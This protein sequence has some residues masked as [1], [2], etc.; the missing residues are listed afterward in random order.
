MSRVDDS[1]GARVG[2][3]RRRRGLTQEQLAERAEVDVS[4]VRKLEQGARDGARLSTLHNLARALDVRT[5]DLF[6]GGGAPAPITADAGTVDLI[7]LREVLTPVGEPEVSQGEEAPDLGR[8]RRSYEAIYARYERNEYEATAQAVP[9][10]ITHARQ[11]LANADGTQRGEA[12]QLLCYALHMAGSLLTQLRRFDLAYFPLREA[13]GLARDGGHLL[14]EA[15]ISTGLAW[16][17]MEQ[18]RLGDTAQVAVDTA[19]RVEPRMSHATPEEI[20]AWGRLLLFASGAAIRNN[21]PHEAADILRLTDTAAANLGDRRPR[22]SIGPF[23]RTIVARRQVENAVIAGD[24]RR[25]LNVAEGIVNTDAPSSVNRNRYLLDVAHAHTAQRDYTEAVDVLRVI[26]HHAPEWLRHQ[27]YARDIMARLLH[28]R[29][30]P[31]TDEMRELADL[32][33]VD[34]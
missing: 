21:E 24:T 16:L 31:V 26:Q 8:L 32:L 20:N 5:S 19:D 22:W 23:D 29:A 11:G 6:G 18:G 15:S 3:L 10:L 2:A 27:G 14:T 13:V 12:E 4:T 1:I 7:R 34:G 17:L 25:A 33:A 30:R 9:E 28:S